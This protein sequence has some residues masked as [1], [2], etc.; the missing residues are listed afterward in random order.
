MNTWPN[1]YSRS[2]F[3]ILPLYA[4]GEEDGGRDEGVS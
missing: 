4:R 3:I 2:E 1:L